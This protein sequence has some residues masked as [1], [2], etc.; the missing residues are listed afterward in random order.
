M[1]RR[2]I[3]LSGQ[4]LTN[5]SFPQGNTTF[6][7]SLYERAR[8][9]VVPLKNSLQPSGQTTILQAMSMGK[10][11]IITQ[12]RGTWTDKFHSNDNCV[13]VQSDDASD[14]ERAI[15]ELYRDPTA[16]ATIGQRGQETVK[17]HYTVDHLAQ[18][19]VSAAK[20]AVCVTL[21]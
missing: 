19:F 4:Q 7:K 16:I 20:N 8:L 12:T 21:R 14:L 15:R 6:L 9:V 5:V 18:A 2:P 17:E 10:P 11:V 13:Y 3:Q 1:T